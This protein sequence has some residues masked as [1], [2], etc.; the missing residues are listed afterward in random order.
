LTDRP[1]I[2]DLRGD[3]GRDGTDGQDGASSWS[4]I[5][6]KPT[7]VA[8][9]QASVSLLGFN[10]DL[11]LAGGD[12]ERVDVLNKPTFFSGSYN[13]LT[14]KPEWVRP[15]QGTANLSE[16]NNDLGEEL[17]GT[18]AWGN[19]SNKP[20]FFNGSY[21]DLADKPEFAD[22]SWEA[23]RTG[24]PKTPAAS[25]LGGSI[26]VDASMNPSNNQSLGSTTA[27][28]GSIHGLG[29]YAGEVDANT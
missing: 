10:N 15:S 23:L 11:S 22:V 7:W 20:T 17:P 13:D 21:N 8:T 14:G 12:V 24:D 18:I 6:G 19:V 9:S 25:M 5:S 1:S 28:W 29:V 27:H 2:E 3:P 26:L 16:F 4:D